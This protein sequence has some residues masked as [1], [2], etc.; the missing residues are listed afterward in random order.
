MQAQR[1]QRLKDFFETCMDNFMMTNPQCMKV[2]LA[3]IDFETMANN[4]PMVNVLCFMVL[5]ISLKSSSQVLI[6]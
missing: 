2:W 6:K 3:S 1:E 5:S 4:L